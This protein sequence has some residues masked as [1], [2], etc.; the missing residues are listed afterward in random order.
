MSYECYMKLKDPQS[1]KNVHTIL[2]HLAT[3]HDLCPIGLM[4]CE[5]MIGNL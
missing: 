3:G 4:C 1:L 5:I 2:A